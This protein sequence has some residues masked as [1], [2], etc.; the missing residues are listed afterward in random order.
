MLWLCIQYETDADFL[1]RLSKATY[2]Q[3]QL[4]A[5]RDKD[6]QKKLVYQALEYAGR[7]LKINDNNANV[8][9][10]FA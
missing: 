8:H 1:W 10:W 9:K 7:A 6:R 5:S 2:F 4:E 3:S